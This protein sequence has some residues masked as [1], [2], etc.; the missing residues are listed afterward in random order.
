MGN[1]NKSK[2]KNIKQKFNHTSVNSEKKKI[3]CLISES[4]ILDQKSLE[5][6]YEENFKN[7]KNYF[8]KKLQKEPT[9]INFMEKNVQK[10]KKNLFDKNSNDIK[11]LLGNIKTFILEKNNENKSLNGNNFKISFNF[12]N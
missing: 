3:S 8:L 6:Y 7:N 10:V 1:E 11:S 2:E 9:L 5:F 4:A 12:Y